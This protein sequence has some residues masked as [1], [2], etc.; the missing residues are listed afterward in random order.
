MNE[1]EETMR[2]LQLANAPLGVN[3]TR[4][5]KSNNTLLYGAIA[6]GLVAGAAASAYWWKGRTRALELLQSTPFERVEELISSCEGKIEDI[7]RTIEEL[8]KKN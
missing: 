7:E 6:L 3:Y 4:E 5:E 1:K 8:K 2:R